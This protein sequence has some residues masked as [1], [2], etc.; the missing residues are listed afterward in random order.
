MKT[1]DGM[2]W[3]CQ[4]CGG[5]AISL[6][7]LRREV[8]AGPVNQIWR[9][10]RDEQCSTGRLC[11]AC[12]KPML[13]VQTTPDRIR[14]GVDVCKRCQFL[15]FDKGEFDAMPAAPPHPQ[16]WENS[17]PQKA[18]ELLAEEEVRR[19][20]ERAREESMAEEGPDEWW[21]KIVGLLGLP[22][23][24]DN[25][26]HCTPWLTWTV[27]AL[28]VLAMALSYSHLREIVDHYGLI[29]S[30]P[31]R[32]GGLTWVTSFFLHGSILHLLSNLYFLLVFGDNVEET[33]GWPRFLL[34]LIASSVA[35]D[36]LHIALEPRAELP[37][38]GASGGI[39][40]VITFYALQFPRAQLGLC[41]RW[42]CYVRWLQISAFWALA[43]WVLLQ[44]VGTAEQ[45]AGFS[46]VSSLAHLGGATVGFLLWLRLRL[47][48]PVRAA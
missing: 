2:I 7:L 35:G 26:V 33:L 4:D 22:V 31:W 25:P 29:A 17:L 6:A 23:E 5:R 36:A 20:G 38:V 43:I 9:A 19:I 48:R 21:Q 14:F 13:I 3:A 27:G 44:I 12:A 8:Q 11:P 32:H 37:S 47:N 28:M 18:R 15:W 45:V 1:P 30:Q 46:N 39:S 10:A 41:W 40:G 42:W 24:L 16:T 34:L